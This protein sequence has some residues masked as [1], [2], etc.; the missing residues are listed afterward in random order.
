MAGR[1]PITVTVNGQVHAGEV[2]PRKLLVHFLRDT[3]GLTGT[4]VGCDTSNCGAC[5]VHLNGDAVKSCTV[6]AVQA[7]GSEV[8]TIEGMG[9]EGDLHPMQEAFWEHHGLQCGYCT[10]GM[11]MAGADLI[12]KNPSPT[13]A[14]VRE[15][16]AGNLCRCTG[17][18][19]IV[20]AVMSA[21][22]Q[23]VTL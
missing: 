5:T 17:Y 6:L 22:G 15:A 14:E 18:H 21:S 1:V 7:D 12:A 9:S 8:T 13:E 3:L 20:K 4:H 19:N 16:L 2:E 10:P 23:E 11:I